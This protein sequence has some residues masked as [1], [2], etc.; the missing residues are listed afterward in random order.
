M[1]SHLK[2]TLRGHEGCGP[3]NLTAFDWWKYIN[4]NIEIELFAGI[5][6]GCGI[7]SPISEVQHPTN[8]FVA[9]HFPYVKPFTC[10]S[11]EELV[12]EAGD[13]PSFTIYF[14]FLFWHF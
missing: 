13:F 4:F 1:G 7:C 3:H 11:R 5:T 10:E 6:I 12:T 14:V 9:G 2:G 8:R